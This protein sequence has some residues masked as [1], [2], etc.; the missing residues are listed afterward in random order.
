MVLAFENWI[1]AGLLNMFGGNALLMSMFILSIFM[2]TMFLLR[3][4]LVIVVPLGISFGLI[5]GL[6]YVPI[7]IIVLLLAGY[8]IGVLFL[9]IRGTDR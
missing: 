1:V 9:S 7:E 8:L 3:L 6:I 2:V 5:V 4:P